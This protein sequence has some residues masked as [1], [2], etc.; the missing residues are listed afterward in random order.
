VGNSGSSSVTTLFSIKSPDGR[1]HGDGPIGASAVP[2]GT[3]FYS[4]LSVVP[5]RYTWKTTATYYTINTTTGAATQV[6][7]PTVTTI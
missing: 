3:G 7:L 4:R 5:A 2:N 6:E 1:H